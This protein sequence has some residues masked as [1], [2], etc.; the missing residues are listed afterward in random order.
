MLE[1]LFTSKTR[2]KIIE[3][4]FFHK[5]ETHLREMAKE[6]E[7]SPSAV[8]RELDNLISLGLIS[9][10]KNKLSLNKSNPFL[11]DLK[12]VFLKTDSVSYP[13]KEAFKKKDIKFVLIFG[14][15]A[16]GDYTPESD[17]DL[18]V[19]GNVKQREIFK[20]LR[21]VEKLIRRDIN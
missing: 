12:K 18:F 5:K 9:K 14:S 4:L 20:L 6:L 21:P 2:I 17:V 1:K 15:F 7:L 13:I 8:K 10:Q 11:E 16:K 19:I 3:Y